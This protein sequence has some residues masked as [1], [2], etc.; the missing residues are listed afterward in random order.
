M[1]FSVTF[2]LFHLFHRKVPEQSLFFFKRQ[3][4]HAGIIGAPQ[5]ILRLSPIE[6][7]CAICPALI[8]RHIQTYSGIKS[9]IF[10]NYSGIFRILCDP[11][12]F[13]ILLYSEPWHIQNLQNQRHIQSPGT[14]RALPYSE[15]FQTSIT[16]PFAKIINCCKKCCSSVKTPYLTQQTFTFSKST[17]ETLEKMPNICSKLTIKM[18]ERR[19]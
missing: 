9:D 6:I 3:I 18:P 17:I 15:P 2:S 11:A 16:E 4:V 10:W 19:H 1:E 14:F 7:R 12:I 8:P 5:K 13:R